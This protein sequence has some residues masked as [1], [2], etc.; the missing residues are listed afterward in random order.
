[1]ASPE[2]RVEQTIEREDGHVIASERLRE[3]TPEDLGALQSF[4]PGALETQDPDA[5]AERLPDIVAADDAELFV[6]RN[7]EGRVV[8][9][10]VGNVNYCMSKWRGRIDDVATDPAYRRQGCAKAL[11]DDAL[12]WFHERGVDKVELISEHEF[13]EAHALYRSRGFEVRD[14]NVFE[15]K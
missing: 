2:Q 4:L 10:I 9:A 14:I 11:L 3:L 15:L 7:P 5:M 6:A 13:T 12:A 8:A 1:M